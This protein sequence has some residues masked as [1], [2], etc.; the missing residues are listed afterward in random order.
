MGLG[1]VLFIWLALGVVAACIGAVVLVVGMLLFRRKLGKTF[2]RSALLVAAFPFACLAWA[3]IVF[4]AQAI[5]NGVVLGRD[6]GIGDG[7]WCPL[8]NGYAI[9]AI[10]TTDTALVYNP[11]TSSAS[12]EIK[13][14]QDAVPD[15]NRMQVEG[16][17][18]FA[19][20]DGD[21][22]NGLGRNARKGYYLLDTKAMVR[23]DFKS[24]TELAAAAAKLGIALNLKSMYWNYG[25][26]RFTWFD[27]SVLVVLLAGPLVGLLLLVQLL[28]RMRAAAKSADSGDSP[29]ST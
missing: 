10:D 29:V 6:P 11:K 12:G 23:E 24:E 26:F 1:F 14:R 3:G 21:T 28:R 8:P 17:Y 16:R 7:F 27:V 22:F 18:I 25:H 15:V 2:W 20:V 13:M 19:A 4:V 5:I 9:S